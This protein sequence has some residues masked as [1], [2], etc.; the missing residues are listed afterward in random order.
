MKG[1]VYIRSG[2][3]EGSSGIAAT[4]DNFDVKKFD[5]LIGC[6][7]FCR[8]RYMSDHGM[9]AFVRNVDGRT[10]EVSGIH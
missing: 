10:A 9:R 6:R 3:A 8:E 4:R 7:Y 5:L 2:I 1:F